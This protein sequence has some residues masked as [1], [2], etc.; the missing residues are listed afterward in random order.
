V[1]A[2]L[3]RLLGVQRIRKLSVIHFIL[4]ALVAWIGLSCFWSV[5]PDSS[6]VRTTTFLQLMFMAWMIWELAPGQDRIKLLTLA[7]VLGTIPTSA[8]TVYNALTGRTAGDLYASAYGIGGPAGTRFA[9]GEFNAN[10]LGLILAIS[11]PMSAYLL[12]SNIR[13]WLRIVCGIQLL[14]VIPSI[15]LTGSRG[16]TLALA[17][18]FVCIGAMFWRWQGPRWIVALLILVLLTGA[19]FTLPKETWTRLLSSGTE[20]TQGTLTHRTNLWSLAADTFRD[21]PFTGVGSGAFQ[22]LSGIAL[23]R[24]LV[25]HNTYLSIVVELGIVGTLIFFLLLISLLFSAVRLPPSEKWLWLG[26]L[27]VWMI[28]VSALTWEYTKTT[29]LIFGLL[30]AHQGAKQE[31]RQLEISQ[32]RVSYGAAASPAGM[33]RRPAAPELNPSHGWREN[34]LRGV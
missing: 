17:P 25:T 28:G 31:A 6:I 30:A 24:A 34:R 7:F 26:V 23:G 19:S 9:A 1:G 14:L 16:S 15:L 3:L 33:V 12:T 29:W 22:R 21:A 4:M 11:V 18:A 32:P 8:N 10:D 13:L 20:I 2:S 5:D 27:S